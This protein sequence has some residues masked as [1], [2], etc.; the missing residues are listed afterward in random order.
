M[1]ELWR[2]WEMEQSLAKQFERIAPT[3]TTSEVA[4]VK[5]SM[6]A[7]VALTD[8]RT[9]FQIILQSINRAYSE[10]GFT[11]PGQDESSRDAFLSQLTILVLADVQESF[12]F[13]SPAEIPIAIRRGIRGEFGD[14]FGLNTVNIHKFIAGH[15]ASVER[16]QALEKQKR[17]NEAMQKEP[18]APS[19]EKQ[20]E[21]MKAGCLKVF[22][23]YKAVGR[24]QDFGNVRYLF[25]EQI[26]IIH[27][28][29]QEKE[30]IYS[31]AE[32]KLKIELS[33]PGIEST[34]LKDYA[35]KVFSD[36]ANYKD[37]VKSKAREIALRSFLSNL[38]A[39][40]SDLSQMISHPDCLPNY[41]KCHER[42][43]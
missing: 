19:L 3:L 36:Q 41:L 30:K 26:G 6:E 34:W 18:E 5:A 13:L 33:L 43:G 27:F 16:S 38:I 24:I 15:I 9:L 12:R 8:E 21:I 23:E 1:N 42:R 14:F 7:V 4:I 32:A 39:S 40:D 11:I 29:I 35:R 20:F 28:S 22:E 17:H 10:L 2:K 31:E 25:L 37:A